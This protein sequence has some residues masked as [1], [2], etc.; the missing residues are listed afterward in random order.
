M[1]NS[2]K[3]LRLTAYFL[4]L[5]MLIL[6]RFNAF[7]Q[8]NLT[9]WKTHTSLYE[10][11]DAAVDSRDRIW[12]GTS[13]GL[14]SYDPEKEEFQAFRNTEGLQ[15][16][17]ITAIETDI[18]NKKIYIGTFDG[19]FEILT[20]DLEWTHILSIKSHTSADPR[21]NDFLLAGND[22]FIAGG[23]G[24]AVFDIKNE[25][26]KE[27]IHKIGSFQSNTTTN[28]L[29]VK[30]DTLWAATVEGLARISLKAPNFDPKY[31]INYTTEN[32]LPAK[33]ITDMRIHG[34]AVYCLTEEFFFK[35]ENGIIDTLREKKL[36]NIVVF[37]GQVIYSELFNIH[38]VSGGIIPLEHPAYIMGLSK[39]SN[40]NGDI[41]IIHYKNRGI[42]LYQNDSLTFFTPN[43][44]L[45]NQFMSMDVDKD[46]TLWAV[47]DG[48]ANDAPGF[49]K[50]EKETWTNYTQDANPDKKGLKSLFGIK[51]FSGNRICMNSWGAGFYYLEKNADSIS[52]T[53]FHDENSIINSTVPNSHYPVIGE[54]DID[55]YN[56]IWFVQNGENTS[57]YLLYSMDQDK[58]LAGYQN[59]ISVSNRNFLNLA[60]DRN[61]TKWAGSNSDFGLYYFNEM[62]T[63][64]NN[65]DDKYGRLTTSDNLLSNQQTALEIDN[66]GQLWVGTTEGV[67]VVINPQAIINSTNV[68]VRREINALRNQ[69]VNDILVDALNF[70]W[71][72]TDNGVW[73]LDQEGEFIT[74][75]TTRNSP[76]VSDKVLSLTTNPSN[77]KIYIG[78]KKG[79]SEVQSLSIKP[80]QDF[81]IICYPQPF[82]PKQDNEM[83]IEGLAPDTDLRI[84]TINGELVKRINSFGRTAVWDGRNSK[85]QYVNS[86]VYLVLADSR[87]TDASSVA[88][89]AVIH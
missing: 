43:T 36:S 47:P 14:Y 54:F 15:S 82:K 60:I 17:D 79:L 59:R 8:F 67:S 85:G 42:G 77:G 5:F 30:N 21:I 62:G 80:R 38:P 41:L 32:G 19:V 70:K 49:M 16:L 61:N 39:S 87:T 55:S 88:K 7:A 81:D 71:I 50:L 64:D 56:N 40:K 65:S 46:G 84:V 6:A 22:L 63:P 26:F 33:D 29:A 34:D 31:W 78:T 52:F 37:E 3:A 2:K 20:E 35:Y 57:G 51:T 25:V 48:R 12:V 11:R 66:S 1:K 72:A 44:P 89:I 83:I 18:V 27:T 9:N 23:F 74:N 28:K 73:V 76:L 86:G 24:I 75:L 69:V 13:G 4:A 10:S 68:F 53:R 58:N 45:P